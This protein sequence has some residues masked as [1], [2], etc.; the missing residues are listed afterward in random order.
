MS[1]GTPRQVLEGGGDTRG[2]TFRPTEGIWPSAHETERGVRIE[3]PVGKVLV[4]GERV[5][6]ARF[7][8][9]PVRR[10]LGV[11][12]RDQRGLAWSAGM[13]RG[14]RILSGGWSSTPGDPC[15][16]ADGREIWFTGESNVGEPAA[17]WAVDL[18]GKRRLVMRVPGHPELDD[19]SKD[20]K[21]LLGH[22]IW[23]QSVRFASDAEPVERE[24]SWLDGSS[25]A[26]LSSAGRTLS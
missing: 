3:F 8:G 19:V 26:D 11:R 9:R 10:V 12:K 24:L 4:G 25:V 2:P 17:L 23:A 20:G 13:A 14:R 16:S 22:H 15:W 5:E 18:S 7:A 6:S 21:A 1:E